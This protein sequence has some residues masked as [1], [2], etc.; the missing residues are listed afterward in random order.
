MKLTLIGQEVGKQGDV[1]SWTGTSSGSAVLDEY[2]G[3]M[4]VDAIEI[5]G[6]YT[7]TD[8]AVD[9]PISLANYME[10]LREASRRKGSPLTSEEREQIHSRC[11]RD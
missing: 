1:V 6:T 4:A 5:G 8:G 2:G 10:G 11:K 7:F 9:K 3:F